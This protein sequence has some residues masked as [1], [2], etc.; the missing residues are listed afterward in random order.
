MPADTVHAK[1]RPCSL[2]QARSFTTFVTWQIVLERQHGL[3]MNLNTQTST[4]GCLEQASPTLLNKNTH[5]QA[6]ATELV[7]PKASHNLSQPVGKSKRIACGGANKKAEHP[8]STC[9]THA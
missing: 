3:N 6:V 1:K 9:A 4:S 7:F 2:G 8:H 5:K